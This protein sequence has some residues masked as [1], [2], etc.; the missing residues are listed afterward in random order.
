MSDATP[1]VEKPAEGA[2]LAPADRGH[3]LPAVIFEFLGSVNWT[4]NS[5]PSRNVNLLTPAIDAV[6]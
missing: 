1:A 4:I 3:V 5:A 2:L 6:G